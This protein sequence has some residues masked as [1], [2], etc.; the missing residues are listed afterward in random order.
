MPC[1]KRAFVTVALGL[2]I[3]CVT[4]AGAAEGTVVIEKLD[5]PAVAR[6]WVDITSV[7]RVFVYLPPGYAGTT[8]SYP[9]LY[10][11]PGW[12]TP[13]SREY[14]PY[15]NAAIS[16]GRIP[17]TIVVHL[18]VSEGVIMM[19]STVFGGWADFLT[20]ELVPYI[21]AE[22]RTVA[23]ER[24][25]AL[26]GHS[27]GGYAAMLLPL[28]YPGIWGAIGLNDA[29]LWAGCTTAV[30]Y[31]LPEYFSQ[32]GDLRGYTQAWTQIAIAMTPNPQSPRLFDTPVTGADY[33]QIKVTWD[34]H[35][36]WRPTTAE[37]QA[38]ALSRLS[39]IA[40]VIPTTLVS[41]NRMYS[42]LFTR[43]LDEIGIEY[44]ALEMPGSHGGDR[45]NRFIA[46][47]E[48]ILPTLRQGHPTAARSHLDT[49]ARIKA[50]R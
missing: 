27:S 6:N 3:I 13:A 33:T 22:Y 31:D 24:G 7:R 4:F 8:R 40:I 12:Q 39:K 11:I 21:D 26:M 38:D 41:T 30:P 14:I 15:L 34:A 46:L 37:S 32:Y 36:L 9:T 48:E 1:C 5:S 17:P 42:L 44:A 28:R 45:P 20:Q 18:D 25:R 19:N 35:C 47:A 29:S 43:A 2:S 16:S 49:W 10:W 50:S 23:H